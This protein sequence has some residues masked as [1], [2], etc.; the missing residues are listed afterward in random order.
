MKTLVLASAVA[1][2]V[3]TGCGTAPQNN[4]AASPSAAPATATSA[5]PAAATAAAPS[6]QPVPVPAVSAKKVVL[7][8]TG[9]KTSVDS[10]DWASFKEEW[11]ATFADHAKDAGI[12]FA[13]QDGE[14]R[15]VGEPGT[16]LTVYVN[17][18][19]QVGIGARIMFGIMTG[20]AY[21]DAKVSFSDLNTGRRFGD[22]AYN[23]TSTAWAGV[24]AKMTPQQ[25]DAIGS[26]VFGELKTR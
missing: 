25:V 23:T 2:L 8:M 22:Q 19:R 5:P 11:R 17:D 13:M 10:K 1:V 4:S 14:P 15:A 26:G 24:F 12:T 16:L 6:A 21:I 7:N 9:T 3:L 20:N 18:Y